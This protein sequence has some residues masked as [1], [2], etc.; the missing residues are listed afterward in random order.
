MISGIL[1]LV[2]DNPRRSILQWIPSY[3]HVSR[4]LYL[5]LEKGKNQIDIN[6]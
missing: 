5:Y 1:D 3:K 4:N 6:S 2:S